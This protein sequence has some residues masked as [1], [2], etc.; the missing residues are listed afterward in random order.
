MSLRV[1]YFRLAAACNYC[2]AAA[3]VIRVTL[4][5]G[6]DLFVATLCQGH[7]DRERE[8][9]ARAGLSVGDYA[10]LVEQVIAGAAAGRK[11]E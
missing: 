11:L 10:R 6:G 3:T 4:N 9:A 7:A 1:E 2:E 5:T 8:H